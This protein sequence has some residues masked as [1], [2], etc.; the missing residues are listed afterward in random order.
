MRIAFFMLASLG[1]TTTIQAQQK[2]TVKLETVL[3]Q[4]YATDKPIIEVPASVGY[5]DATNFQRFSNTS[6]LPAVNTI[7]GVRMEERSPGSYRFSIRGSLLRSPFG[8]RNVKAYWNGLPLTDGGGNTYLNLLD[9]DAVGSM[10][11][12]KG[13]GGSLYGAGTGG[14]LLLKT[15]SIRKNQIEVSGV[16]GSYGL[17]RFNVTGQLHQENLNIRLNYGRLSYDGYRE[18][19]TMQRDALNADITYQ[20]NDKSALSATLFYTDLK[21]ETPGGLTQSQYDENPK[22]ARPAAGPNRSAI[23]Q[24]AAVYNTTPYLG[25]SYDHEWNEKWSTRI[26]IFGSHSDFRNAAIGNYELRDESNIGGRAETQYTFGEH[27][28]KTKVTLGGEY[29]YLKSPIEIHANDFGAVGTLQTS[30]NLTS[31][32]MFLFGQA[33]IHLPANF[34]LTLGGSINFLQYN[35]QQSIPSVVDEGRNFDPAFSPRIALLNKITPELSLYASVSQGFSPP[36][37]AELFPSRAIFD[38]NLNPEQGDNYEAGIKGAINRSLNFDVS[39]Y[40][41]RLKETIVIRRDATLAGEPEY[42]VNAGSTSQR[43]IEGTLSWKV[44]KGDGVI[45]EFTIWNTYTMNHYRFNQFIKDQTDFR[46]N[47]LTGVPPTVNNS[48]LDILFKNIIGLNVTGTYVDHIPLNDANTTFASEYF[49]LGLKVSVSLPIAQAHKLD[50]FGGIDNA[51]DKKYSLG[52][53][54]NAFGGRF[55]NAAPPRNYYVGLKY[56]LSNK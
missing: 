24:Q 45:S 22:Q 5:L 50:F 3:I 6:I 13:P 47:K 16:T 48:G 37:L 46:G 7:P 38:K 8:V 49:L 51:L 9:F 28:R 53:D 27:T 34:Y 18:Q 4:A 41:F 36:T 11:V 32:Q 12:I 56:R 31:R 19:T 54:L 15:P 17:R 14:V 25:L 42:F 23:E 10:E 21:Y 30:S 44:M 55:F 26:G 52:N 2:D 43:G 39:A 40:S 33:D 20:L 1:I 29:Q 35:F